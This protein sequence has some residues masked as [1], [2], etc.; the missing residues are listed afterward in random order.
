M[1]CFPYAKLLRIQNLRLEVALNAVRDQQAIVKTHTDHCAAIQQKL[2]ALHTERKDQQERM[3]SGNCNNLLATRL[4]QRERMIHV[5]ADRQER[6][7]DELQ[8][9]RLA[10]KEASDALA[11]ELSGYHRA[12][13]KRDRLCE[14]EN[15]WK[16]GHLRA[17]ASNEDEELSE[18]ALAQTQ[19][20]AMR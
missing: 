10:H 7:R 20:T 12:R 11:V 5:N 13:V 18:F 6:V 9:A 14:R 19:C 16:R 1:K 2:A 15:E 8:V 17:I 3:A 4:A